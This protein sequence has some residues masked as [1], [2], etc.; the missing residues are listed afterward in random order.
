MAITNYSEL[1]SFITDHLELD[2][3]TVAKLPALIALAENELDRLIDTPLGEVEAYT[4]TVADV[5]T[6][7]VPSDFTRMVGA[8][9]E[10]GI[11][12]KSRPLDEIRELPDTNTGK[13]TD[14]AITDGALRLYPT[15][16]AAYTITILYIAGIPPL[17][18]TNTSNWLLAKAPDAYVY[19][20]LKHVEAW[21]TNDTRAAM[22]DGQMRSIVDQINEQ[23][24]RYRTPNHG[25]LRNRELVG[26]TR[27]AFSIV[28]G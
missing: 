25:Q 18:V 3:A 4:D 10:D 6:V 1:Q 28:N 13:P 15:P 7:A 12:L 14:Y 24:M 11:A 8:L 20:S 27:S 17:S 19:A 23:G 21:L 5:R 16:D 2:A 9:I 26:M 22:F